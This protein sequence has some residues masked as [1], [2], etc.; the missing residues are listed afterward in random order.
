MSHV[1]LYFFNLKLKPESMCMSQLY[2]YSDPMPIMLGYVVSR[3]KDD[4]CMLA[5]FKSTICCD[6]HIRY[7]VWK[8]TRLSGTTPLA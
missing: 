2:C 6:S 7:V 5:V 1:I 8:L 3:N 4:K